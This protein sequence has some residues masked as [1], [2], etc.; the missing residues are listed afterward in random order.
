M[1][2]MR[3]LLITFMKKADGK[4][5][6][7]V[8]VAKSIKP[9]DIQTCNLILDFKEKKVEKCMVNGTALPTTWDSIYEYYKNIYPSILERLDRE[10]NLEN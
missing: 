5:D 10:A 6:E 3:Y 4:I 8:Q 2:N 7:Q 1:T 9:K